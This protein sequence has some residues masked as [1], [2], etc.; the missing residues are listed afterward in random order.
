PITRTRGGDGNILVYGKRL[1]SH[2]MMQPE[3]SDFLFGNSLLTAQGILSRCLVAR[4]ESKIGYQLYQEANVYQHTA[5]KR[6]FARLLDI[7]EAP[8]PL[9]EGTLKEPAPRRISLAPAAK[10]LWIQFHNHI[11]GL[12]RPEQ[13]LAPVQGL[14]AKAAEHVVRLA[15][16]L[17]LIDDLLASE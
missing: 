4:P 6:Y 12:M 17:T 16:I 2:L 15:G 7:L 13:P 9:A 1:S 10:H 8:F 5:M 11:Q 3:V 14:A